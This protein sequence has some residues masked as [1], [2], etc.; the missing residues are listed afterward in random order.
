V[1]SISLAFYFAA[2]GCGTIEGPGGPAAERVAYTS[3]AR[4]L[5]SGLGADE[6]LGGYSRH[7]KTF[8]KRPEGDWQA[9]VDELQ[10]VSPAQTCFAQADVGR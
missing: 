10:M 6:L 2:R 9:L 8:G 1:Q 3:T 7:R 5:L 4:V